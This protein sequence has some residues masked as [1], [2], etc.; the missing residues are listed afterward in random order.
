MC[1][2]CSNANT[3]SPSQGFG[4]FEKWVKPDEKT[5]EG[6]TIQD[7]HTNKADTMHALIEYTPSP[8]LLNKVNYLF[9]FVLCLLVS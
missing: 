5:K 2:R 6:R 1:C 9:A 7:K 4:G 8:I 3:E